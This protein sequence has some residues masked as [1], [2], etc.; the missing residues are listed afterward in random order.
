MNK[1]NKIFQR[2]NAEVYTQIDALEK[3]IRQLKDVNNAF[4][5]KDNMEYSQQFILMKET[6]ISKID[7]WRM[8]RS[9][10]TN[11]PEAIKTA[12]KFDERLQEIY[13]EFCDSIKRLVFLENEKIN[14]RFYHLYQKAQ[15]ND[16][17]KIDHKLT[18]SKIFITIP[19]LKNEFLK[20]VDDSLNNRSQTVTYLYQDWRNFAMR[21][22]SPIFDEIIDSSVKLLQKD[23]EWIAVCYHE[24]LEKLITSSMEQKDELTKNLSDVAILLQE[25]NDWINHFDDLLFDLE[26]SPK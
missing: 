12:E 13:G 8:W 19:T 6:A 11:E 9:K 23:Y 21:R 7:N 16:N 5:Q 14:E 26:R 24:H 25:D 2:E 18:P 4:I 10:I 20:L 1:E 17:F 3:R 22:L 15:V